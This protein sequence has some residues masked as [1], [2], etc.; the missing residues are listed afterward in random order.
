MNE[1]IVYTTEGYTSA[2]ETNV[3][4]ENCQILGI[5]EGLSEED[6]INR[7]FENNE[8]IPKAG[9]TTGNAIARSL[10]TASIKE[11]IKTVIEYLW[12][13]EHKHFQENHYPQ[14]HIFRILRR[15][16]DVIR[17]IQLMA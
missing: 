5:A 16:Q 13:D 14:N 6:A 8:W 1:Y 17:D 4:I 15:L 12:K 11:D 7:L 10:L 2:P 9:F 3:N